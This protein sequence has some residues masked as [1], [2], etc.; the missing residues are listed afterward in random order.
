MQFPLDKDIFQISQS[1]L[2][3]GKSLLFRL[4]SQCSA[5]SFIQHLVLIVD[6]ILLPLSLPLCFKFHSNLS[7]FL[8]F[9]HHH[10]DLSSYLSPELLQKL[11]LWFA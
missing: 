6:T 2:K 5:T 3:L 1:D 4:F 10:P 7:T 11:S 8:H 9:Y